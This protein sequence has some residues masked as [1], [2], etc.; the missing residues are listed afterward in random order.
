ML[1]AQHVGSTDGLP[2]VRVPLGLDGAQN[3]VTMRM[4]SGWASAQQP[5]QANICLAVATTTV[6]KQNYPPTP[7][8]MLLG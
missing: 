6:A 3:I 4:R 5:E 1:L 7:L 8:V 2:A